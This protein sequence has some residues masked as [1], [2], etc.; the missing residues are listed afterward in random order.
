MIYINVNLMSV[1]FKTLLQL[2]YFLSTLYLFHIMIPSV[3]IYTD[4]FMQLFS[5]SERRKALPTDLPFYLPLAFISLCEFELFS[6]GLSIQPEGLPLDF[7]WEGLLAMNFLSF[8]LLENIL[9][10]PTFLKDSFAEYRILG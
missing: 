2:N 8:C 3:Q 5:K 9:I 7:L 6:S 4:C 1:V 10:S